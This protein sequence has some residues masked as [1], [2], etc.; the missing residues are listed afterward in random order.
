MTGIRQFSKFPASNS[1]FKII[2]RFFNYMCVSFTLVKRHGISVN[3]KMGKCDEATEARD[4][5]L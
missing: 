4:S 3:M 1:E 2:R 5:L